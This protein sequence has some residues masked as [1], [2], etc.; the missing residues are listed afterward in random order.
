[1]FGVGC[2]LGGASGV[3]GELRLMRQLPYGCMA[4]D[5][6]RHVCIITGLIILTID[7]NVRALERVLLSDHPSAAGQQHEAQTVIT[8][9]TMEQH[10]ELKKL[11]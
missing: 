5:G 6:F 2:L 3:W 1:M 9:R 4:F 7:A 11:K 8:E 10:Q